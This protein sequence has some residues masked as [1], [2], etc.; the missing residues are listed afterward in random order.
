MNIT[1]IAIENNRVT[2]VLLAVIVLMGITTY[3]T[4]SRDSMP[5]Y[6]VRVASVVTAFPGASPDRVEELVTDKI[7]EVAQ[8]IPEVKEISSESRTG[9]SIVNVTVRDDYPAEDLQKIWDLLRRKIDAI[10]DFPDGIRPPNVKDDDVG[11]VYGIIIGLENDG[12]DYAEL[13][14]FADEVRDELIKLQDASRV[15]ISGVQEEE[16][17]IEFDNA[18]LARYGLSSTQLKNTIAGINI[19]FSG[20]EVSLED[21]R[22]ILEPTGNFENMEDLQKTIIAVGQDGETVYLG[23]ITTIKRGYKSPKENSVRVNGEEALAI[24]V[25]LKDGANVIR[26]GEAIDEKLKILNQTLP[27]GLTLSRI[28]SQDTVVGKSISDFIENMIQS[29]IIV[30]AVMLLFLGFRTGLVVASLIP[31]TI[32]VTIFLMGIGDVGLNQVSLAALIMALGML[33][34]NAIVVSESIMVKMEGGQD[35]KVAAIDSAKELTIPLFI[36]SLTTSAAFLSFFLAESTMGDIVGPLFV[37]ITMALVSS[38]LISLTIITILAYLFIKVKKK[39]EEKASIFDRLIVYYEKML[40]WVLK[41]SVVFIIS[42][43]VMFIGSIY[44]FGYIPFIFSPDS[45]R[46]LV[47][48]D[49]NLPLGTKIERTTEITKK[50]EEYIQNELIT[51]DSDSAK[52]LDFA[53]YIGEGPKSYDLGYSPGE[54]NAG[55][56]HL[57]VNTTTNLEN[58]NV[59]A[60]LDDF[61]FENFPDADVKVSALGSGGGGG[62]DVEIRIS[63]KS[64]EELFRLSEIV[65][66]KM[67]T[68]PG[69]KNIGDDWGPKIKKFVVVIDQNKAQKAGLSNQDIAVSLQT[70]LNGS[71]IG[72]FREGDNSIPIIMR[73]IKSDEQTVQTLENLNIY[74]QSSGKN[75]PLSQVAKITTEWQYAKI[76]RHDLYR[77]INVQAYAKEGITATDITKELLPWLA[78]EAKTWKPGYFYEQGG[79]AEN[80]SEN[81][82]AVAAYLPLSGFIILLLLVVQFNSIRKTIIVVSTIPLGIIGVVIGLFAFNSYFGFFG[83]LG[84]I[85]LAGIVINNAIVLIDRIQIELDEFNRSPSEAVIMA[86]KQRFRPI[87]LTTFTTTLSL[88]PLYLGG[89]AMWEP[90]AVAIMVGL[91]FATVITLLF[92][93]VLYKIFYKVKFENL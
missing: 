88:I 44:G 47:T 20:G 3:N 57:L 6:T 85:S 82:G 58:N 81:M 73:D 72:A 93:P 35:A 27:V 52:V 83:F 55:Y 71:T 49:M 9:L 65:K 68:I 63:G 40:H 5:P 7:E 39:K 18:K 1:K 14:E 12:F 28:A 48:V 77:T 86:A 80:S 70:I 50:I 4:L 51:K 69:T 64:P 30:L 2:F 11:V 17:F 23:D 84:V 92:V 60:L 45:D 53:S 54:A 33:V 67:T 78:E 79:E 90:M 36:A 59:I 66:E 41:H 32:I 19:I 61:C 76:N 74:A 21:E 89:G 29:I 10:N 8:E 37:V 16:I 43:I 46:N 31:I 38:W 75:V 42:L 91:L 24:S 62:A 87:L 15:Y 34:D 56:A 26:L 25:S 22:I 13:K